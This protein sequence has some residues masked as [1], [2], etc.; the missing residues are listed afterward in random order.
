MSVV[1]H[2]LYLVCFTWFII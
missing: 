1:L 2:W